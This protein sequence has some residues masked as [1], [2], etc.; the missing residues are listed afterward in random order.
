MDKMTRQEIHG[1][2]DRVL[3]ADSSD[4]WV[5]FWFTHHRD[6]T[7]VLSVQLRGMSI[8]QEFGEDSLQDVV[9][10]AKEATDE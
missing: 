10:R 2:L 4:G 8:Q 1:L 6:G 7:M 9:A 3:D 5:K